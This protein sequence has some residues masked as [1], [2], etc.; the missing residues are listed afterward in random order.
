M[1]FADSVLDIAALKLIV[2][3]KHMIRLAPMLTTTKAANACQAATEL[4]GESDWSLPWRSRDAT[5]PPRNLVLCG[6]NLKHLPDGDRKEKR[7]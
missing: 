7:S 6:V 2:S 5:G 4:K 1:R 3:M